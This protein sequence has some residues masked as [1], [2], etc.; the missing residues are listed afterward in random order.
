M[1]VLIIYGESYGFLEI[2]LIVFV[3]KGLCMGEVLDGFFFGDMFFYGFSFG[4]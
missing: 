1:F 2:M 4:F 3:I